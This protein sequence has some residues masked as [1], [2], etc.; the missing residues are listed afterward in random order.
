M[1][2]WQGFARRLNL[3][4]LHPMHARLQRHP[5][6]HER[7]HAERAQ[8][9]YTANDRFRGT[10]RRPR[11][12]KS[13]QHNRREDVEETQ[14]EAKRATETAHDLAGVFLAKIW[15]KHT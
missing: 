8:A 6:K 3:E 9:E 5:A 13:Q 4:A 2:R 10:H 7:Q 12:A 1:W 14:H 11:R 15:I